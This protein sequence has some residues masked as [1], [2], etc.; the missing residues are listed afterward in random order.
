MSATFH[1][2]DILAPAAAHLL[3]G[4]DPDELGPRRPKIITLANFEPRPDDAG[5]VGEVIFRDAF[6]NLITNVRCTSLGDTPPADWT[7]EVAGVRITGLSQTYGDQPAGISRGAR[8]FVR[9]AGGG[10]RQRRRGP[11]AHRRPGDDGLVSQEASPG[12]ELAR[13]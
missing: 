13:R 11:I 10:G 3:L 1:G 9:M 2:R 8:R 6:G 4:R 12:R 5:I 7:V